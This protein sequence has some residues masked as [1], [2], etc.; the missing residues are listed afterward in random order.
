M[1]NGTTFGYSLF[2]LSSRGT[3][4]V[5]P[6]TPVYVGEIIG[7]CNKEGDLNVNPCKN[8]ELT[9]TRSAHADEAITLNKAKKFTLEEALEFIASDEYIEVTPDEIRLRKKYLDP[10][11]RYRRSH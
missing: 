1:E 3:M 11:E 2:N 9:N 10:K 5:D 8:K 4:I 6:S 7:I